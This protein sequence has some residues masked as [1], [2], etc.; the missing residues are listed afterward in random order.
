MKA[1]KPRA[2]RRLIEKEKAKV[3]NLYLELCM[4][5]QSDLFSDQPVIDPQA[6][7]SVDDKP[8]KVV[9]YDSL[10]TH[11]DRKWRRIC[12]ELNGRLKVVMPDPQYFHNDYKPQIKLERVGLQDAA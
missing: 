3:S 2:L 9:T 8:D 5:F 12:H 6:P 7:R 1:L 10:F 11:Y 4:K